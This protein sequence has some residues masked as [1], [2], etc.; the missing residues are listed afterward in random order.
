MLHITF[1]L[2]FLSCANHA[3]C[4][5]HGQCL[6]P[7]SCCCCCCC[8]FRPCTGSD[9]RTGVWARKRV[10]YLLSF[11]CRFLPISCC[12]CCFCVV[13]LAVTLVLIALAVPARL[14]SGS[15]TRTAMIMLQTCRINRAGREEA[16]CV[17]GKCG[18]AAFT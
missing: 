10:L 1:C 9:T 17:C 16:V 14:G 2:A 15:A 6:P 13:F 8:C 3:L 7:S 5:R 11:I 18:T 4:P 12:C